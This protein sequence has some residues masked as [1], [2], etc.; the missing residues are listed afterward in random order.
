MPKIA[1]RYT[2]EIAPPYIIC[3]LKLSDDENQIKWR[4]TDTIGGLSR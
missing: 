1:P 2:L 4:V 3:R